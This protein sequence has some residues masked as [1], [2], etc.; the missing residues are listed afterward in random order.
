[1]RLKCRMFGNQTP[2]GQEHSGSRVTSCR[3]RWRGRRLHLRVR[4]LRAPPRSWSTAPPPPQVAGP[5]PCPASEGSHAASSVS[6]Y[7]HRSPGCR[8]RPSAA[9]R[10]EAQPCLFHNRL[11]SGGAGRPS[12]ASCAADPLS[13]GP[14]DP[15]GPSRWNITSASYRTTEDRDT[16]Q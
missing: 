14:A 3:G 1:M 15:R 13:P 10:W 12:G 7:E 9:L 16:H 8:P 6:P 5:S 2:R 4:L 11:R